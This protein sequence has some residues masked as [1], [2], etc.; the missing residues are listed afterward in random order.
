[1]VLKGAPVNDC[2]GGVGEGI[3]KATE[4]HKST[5]PTLI[6]FLRVKLVAPHEDGK[7]WT[8]MASFD[9]KLTIGCNR[10]HSMT[11]PDLVPL[12]VFHKFEFHTS[13]SYPNLG[14][15]H[16]ACNV[17]IQFSNSPPGTSADPV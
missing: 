13:I 8:K 16:S 15:A 2:L 5:T 7:W 6:A 1:M 17:Q 11:T 9:C 4:S 14:Q 12:G 10:Y 3:L